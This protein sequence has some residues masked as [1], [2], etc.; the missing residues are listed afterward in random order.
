MGTVS[1]NWRGQLTEAERAKIAG[2]GFG[3]RVGIGKRPAVLVIDVQN[4]MVG[5]PPG[6]PDEPYPSACAD[7][8]PAVDVLSSFLPAMRALGAP[9]FYTRFELD[10]DGSDGGVYL[11]KRDLLRTGG[12]C[13]TGSVGAQI[14][15]AVAPA[16]GDVVMVK[17]KPSGF[18]GTPL[19][20]MLIDR[21][22]DSVLVVGGSTS[23]CVRA[24]SVDAAS[25]NYR[26]TI[27]EDAVFDRFDRSHITTLF[28]LDRQYGDVR[29][30]ADIVAELTV[31]AAAVN[32]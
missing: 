26:T 4:Y 17:K 13:L 7:G 24:T 8:G 18:F 19:L 27:V 12:W 15:P 10:P 25:Y 32:S 16:D 28:D 20:S 30:A 29:T 11:R 14:V 22:V 1:G 21:G 2:A 23:N 5:P 6:A 9:I 3:R 31:R